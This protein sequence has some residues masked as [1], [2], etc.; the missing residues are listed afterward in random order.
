MT[1]DMTQCVSVLLRPYNPCPFQR[2]SVIFISRIIHG[3]TITTYIYRTI[4][5]TH[6]NTHTHMILYRPC[7][8]RENKENIFTYFYTKSL[9]D[10]N[11]H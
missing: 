6:L 3:Y 7:T 9:I 8:E 1:C 10:L 2:F 11:G 4:Q 5:T